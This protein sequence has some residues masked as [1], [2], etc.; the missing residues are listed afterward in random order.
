[1]SLWESFKE[2]IHPSKF[3]ARMKDI[4]EEQLRLVRTLHLLEKPAMSDIKAA[5]D[6]A[7]EFH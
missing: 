5:T 7:A 4:S 6:K 3:E 2:V 1:M